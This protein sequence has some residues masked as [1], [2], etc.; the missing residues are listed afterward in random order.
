[1]LDMNNCFTA[2]L[3]T[4]VRKQAITG[5][6]ASTNLIDLDAANV[7]MGVGR[8]Q[9]RL[10]VRVIDAFDNLTSLEIALET[11]TAVGFATAKKQIMI[12][13]VAAAALIA[14]AL[15]V[16]CPLPAQ[17][18]QQYMRLYFNVVGSNPAAGSLVGY[19]DDGADSGISQLDLVGA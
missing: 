14:G 18:Y 6:A 17:K 11:D 12:F 4:N 5:D 9:P 2:T 16:D 1:M 19:L 10:K 7:Q 15:V 8:I 3:T 13:N